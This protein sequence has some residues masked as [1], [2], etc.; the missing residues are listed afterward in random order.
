MHS[1]R[2]VVTALSLLL[3]L[4]LLRLAA[5][6]STLVED[7]RI[8]TTGDNGARSLL[9]VGP[10]NTFGGGGIPGALVLGSSGTSPSDMD[11]IVFDP[12]TAFDHAFEVALY[13]NS[14]SARMTLGS[15]SVSEPGDD[16]EILLLD[17][18]GSSLLELDGGTGNIEQDVDNIAIANGNGAVKA[19]AKIDADG[20]V[21]QCWKCNLSAAQTRRL[22][23]GDYEVDFELGNIQA[24][25]RLA[26][27]DS[28]TTTAVT[29]FGV[30]VFGSSDTS[31]VRVR[32]RAL[33]DGVL[34]DAAFTV[35]VF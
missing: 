14:S 15:G 11:L 4:G 34:L 33:S 28:H 10:L 6:Q 2:T 27:I 23:E 35:F 29:S 18:M 13:F 19:W 25:P 31:T 3:T 22:D 5:A 30:A 12:S 8:E 21:F 26:I 32:T 1:S 7:G 20:T 9:I 24:R 16:G 17:G